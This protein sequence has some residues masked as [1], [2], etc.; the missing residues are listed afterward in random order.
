MASKIR[1]DSNLATGAKVSLKSTISIC[2]Y[3]CAT[4]LALFLVIVP[5]SSDLFLNI[6]LVTITFTLL[7]IGT[8]V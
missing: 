6:H 7:G 8:S 1:T 4:S 5:N 2:V 3:P